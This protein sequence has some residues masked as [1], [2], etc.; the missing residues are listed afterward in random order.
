[1]LRN[2]EC[3]LGAFQALTF[4]PQRLFDNK[5]IAS[6]QVQTASEYSSETL[7]FE[8]ESDNP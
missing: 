1:M 8:T 2:I 6:R 4:N 7:V 3:L 5:L